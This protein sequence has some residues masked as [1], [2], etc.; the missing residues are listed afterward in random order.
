MCERE[1]IILFVYS[2][3]WILISHGY[4]VLAII[5]IKYLYFHTTNHILKIVQE[6]DDLFL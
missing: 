3:I 4:Q 1:K 5:I 6:G 2:I